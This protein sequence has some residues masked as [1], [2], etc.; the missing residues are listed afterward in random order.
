[1]KEGDRTADMIKRRMLDAMVDIYFGIVTPTQA[2]MMLSGHAPPVPKVIVQEVKKALVD[3]EKV[4]TMK[5]LKTLEKIVKMYKDYEHGKLKSVPGKEI[6]DLVEESK[7]YGKRIKV[8]RAKLEKRMQEKQAEKISDTTFDLMKKLFGNMREADLLAAFEKE[9][10]KK[11]KAPGRMLGIAKDVAGLKKKVKGKVLGQSEMQ[12]ETGNASDLIN[13]LTEYAQ[14]KELVS[15]GRGIVG[16]TYKD[17][18]AE[19]VAT[20]HG[21]FVVQQ[22]GMILVVKGK[23]LEESTREALEKALG[24]TKERLKFNLDSEMIGI[25]NAKYEKFSIVF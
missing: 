19:I 21:V 8:M 25:M 24:E 18:K 11:G 2:M 20:D 16:F 3:E 9:V 13:S 4:M 12:R 15:L 1:M 17:G 7:E 5:E 14:R 10:I 6:D 23:K 22:D